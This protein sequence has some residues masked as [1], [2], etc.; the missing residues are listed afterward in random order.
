VATEFG[1]AL[2]ITS[3]VFGIYFWTRR[4]EVHCGKGSRSGSTPSISS[5]SRLTSV[6]PTWPGGR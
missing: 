2:A 6:E 1:A 4:S 3:A 5:N